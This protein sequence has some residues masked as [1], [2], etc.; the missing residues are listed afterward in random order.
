MVVILIR[1]VVFG[2]LINRSKL[3]FSFFFSFF[4]YMELLYVCFD[5]DMKLICK[6]VLNMIYLLYLI[7]KFLFILY[8]FFK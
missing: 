1:I 3:D 7:F 8:F 4:V 6:N 2:F 5:F